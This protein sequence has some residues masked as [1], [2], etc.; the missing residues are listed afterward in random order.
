MASR[1]LLCVPRGSQP[2]ERYNCNTDDL[3]GHHVEEEAARFSSRTGS[4][5]TTRQTTMPKPLPKVDCKICC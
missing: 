4:P 3:G 5:R 1:H 2:S